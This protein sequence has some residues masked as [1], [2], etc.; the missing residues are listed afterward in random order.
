MGR[1]VRAAAYISLSLAVPMGRAF[2]SNR[3]YCPA[4]ADFNPCRLRCVAAVRSA[5]HAS[6]GTAAQTPAAMRPPCSR[7]ATALP[8]RA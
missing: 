3:A 4:L 2:V 1:L 6:G 8:S 7:L 5:C